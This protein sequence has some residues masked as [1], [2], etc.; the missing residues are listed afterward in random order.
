MK[1]LLQFQADWPVISALLDEA[2]NLPT[3]EH[4]AWLNGLNDEQA[5]YREALR[6]LLAHQAG[7]ETDDFL[8]R[9]PV[10]ELDELPHSADGVRPGSYIGAY[11]LISEIARG[12]MGT[13]WLAERSDGLMK[14]RVALK[15]PR[16]VWGDTFAERLGRE[17]EILAGLEHQHIARLYDAGVDAQGR[18]FLA[19]EYVEGQSIDAYCQ[20]HSPSVRERIELLLQV[21][22]A[23]AHAH[24]RLV[25]H[26]DLKPA[27]IL[28]TPTGEVR[29]LDF[30]IAKLME[31][32]RTNATA[33]TELDGRALTLDYASPEQIRGE[34]LGTASDI[35]SMAVVAY[36]VLSGTRPYRLKRASAA[37]L[38]EAIASIEPPLASSSATDP[39]VAR[40][41]RGDLDSILNRALKK[42]P[43]ERYLTMDAF[44][45]DL[46]HFLRGE[47]VE[48]RPDRWGYRASKFVRRHRLQMA[49]G[50][51]VVA[52]LVAGTSVAL[53]Q[54]RVARRSAEQARTEAHRA[55]VEAATAKA[56]QGFIESVFNANSRNEAD[57]EAS[58]STTARELLDRGAERIDKDLASAPEAQLRLY[59]LLAEMYV[60]MGL[61]ERALGLERRGL[62]LAIRLHGPESA[63]A[64]SAASD[65]GQ[66]LD[67]MGQRDE[68]LATLLRADEAARGRHDD[69]DSARMMIDTGLARVY[70]FTE[71]PKALERA[72]RA[73]EIAR[74]LGP[75]QDGIGAL[76]ML[77]IMARKSGYL[78]EARQA[79]MDEAAWIDQQGDTGILGDLFG[80]LGELQSDLGQFALAETTLNRS[81]TLAENTRNPQ[82]LHTA[83]YR[84][85]RFQYENRLLNDALKTA[86]PE[87]Q[88][89]HTLGRQ[90]EFGDL[91]T[92]VMFNFGRTLAAYG[93]AARGL[94]AID[95]AR[96][97]LPPQQAAD[98]LGML[99][100]AR[101]EALLELQRP[102]EAHADLE[103]AV[104][105]TS[106]AGGPRA[107]QVRIIRRR[108]LVAVG[109][110]DEALEDFSAN[111]LKAGT[112]ANTLTT[113]RREAEHATL[114]LAAGQDDMARTT[115]E[116]VR[117]A[118]ERLPERRFALN[119]E[120]RMSALVGEA[121]LRDGHAAEAAPALQK[122]LAM[123]VEQYDPVRNPAVTAL[124]RLL[125]QAQR[126]T[127]HEGM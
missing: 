58:R 7:I 74:S 82:N 17:R 97:L 23:V 78:E 80:V 106:A 93:D 48:A 127:K 77:A 31:A 91:P 89:V 123:Y 92:L 126:D 37:E 124:R 83:R 45:Q 15:L 4:A 101:A 114:L 104:E 40:H 34:S 33:L 71:L 94:A 72:R 109:K 28:V 20:V 119:T 86:D 118:I 75:S 116:R 16:V 53:W 102:D 115:A 70:S 35:Y 8:N 61:Q 79:L 107:E 63:V 9:L 66:T 112:P 125:A 88:W 38:E 39:R 69:R 60:G 55:E 99:L 65:L 95:E 6:S 24:A 50:T 1:P 110:A 32:G 10:L 96:A 5:T 49:A 68:A 25:V 13:V 26:R 98:R 62:A 122:A 90:H 105:M 30:G 47:P 113:L 29:L 87:V 111:P 67:D 121:L 44:A 100:A 59:S 22:A 52:A 12:G 85:A 84:L 56:V 108:Y 2:L 73:A 27:N 11:R 14:R 81:I 117:A 3:S 43:G 19:M 51:V 103:R 64:L 36:E 41:L 76:A 57:P 42:A 120:A 54:A 46:Q 21:M 18:P